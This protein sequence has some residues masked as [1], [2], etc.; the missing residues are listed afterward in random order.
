[1]GDFLGFDE[2]GVVPGPIGQPR[3]VVA[4]AGETILPTHK[5]SAMAGETVVIGGESFLVANARRLGAAIDRHMTNMLQQYTDEVL[6]G[7]LEGSS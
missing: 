6:V 1:M 2:G 5:D 3:L 7:V 4:H